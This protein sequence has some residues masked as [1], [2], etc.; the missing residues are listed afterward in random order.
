MPETTF[1]TWPLELAERYREL[2]Y[3][4]GKDL[5]ASVREQTRINPDK[6]ALIDTAGRKLTYAELDR[7][8][9]RVASALRKWGLQRGD[10]FILQLPNVIELVTLLLGSIR[11]GVIPVMVLPTHREQEVSHLARGSGAVA[12]VVADVEA[13]YDFR[14]LA[15]RVKQAAPSL[16]QILVVGDTGGDPALKSYGELVDLEAE[17][18]E[19]D[20]IDASSVALFLHSGGTGGL[21]KLIPRTHNDYEYNARASAELCG[22]DGATVYLASL[23]AAHNF[24]LA[25]PGILGTFIA[26]GTVV[27]AREPSPD[28]VFSLIARH[29]VTV[30]AAVPTLAALWLEAREFDDADLSSLRVLQVGGAKLAPS[31][32]A[33]IHGFLG[34]RVQQVFGMAEGLLNFTRDEDPVDL[35]ETTQGRPLSPHD[36]IRLVDE[37]GA[38]VSDGDVGELWTRGPYT[39]RAYGAAP[40]VNLRA[41]TADGFYRTGDLVRRL[42]TGHLVV[43][44]RAGDQINR[45][46]EKFS[47]VEIEEYLLDHPAVRDIAVIGVPDVSLG[48]ASCAIVRPVERPPSLRDLRDFLRSRGV[49]TYKFPDTIRIVD[50]I[51]LTR[52]G[53]IDRK[54][55]LERFGE[56]LPDPTGAPA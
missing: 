3:W 43:E 46:A 25:C 42:P 41:F 22:F 18:A 17:P 54:R 53:K 13:S 12:Y 24:P 7:T 1:Q 52:F 26:G 28:T 44:G 49:A 30:T 55:L 5:T 31:V 10:R 15:R 14:S 39:I 32:A 40:E 51:P 29:R 35:V 33:R 23:S 9:D 47:S 4:R 8:T 20:D 6:I 36:E 48:Q 11:A 56:A 16:R 2:G 38:D 21:P 37:L 19:I 50:E 45:G 27:L 34:V